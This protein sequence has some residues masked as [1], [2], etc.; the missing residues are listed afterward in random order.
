MF[1]LYLQNID[2]ES[3]DFQIFIEHYLAT[4]DTRNPEKIPYSEL[5]GIVRDGIKE[6]LHKSKETERKP[7]E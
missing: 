5:Y 7:R 4:K 2:P 6:Y 3:A 1:Q